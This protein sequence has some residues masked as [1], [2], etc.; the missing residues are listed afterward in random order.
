MKVGIHYQTQYAYS[1]PVK[2]DFSEILRVQLGYP[3]GENAS[4]LRRLVCDR[5]FAEAP[6]A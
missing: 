6:P 3:A 2:S 4:T 1:S 5:D